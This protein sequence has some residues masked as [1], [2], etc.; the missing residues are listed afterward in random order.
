MKRLQRQA[1]LLAL[2]VSVLLH[3]ALLGSGW[4]PSFAPPP[5]SK[6]DPI[7]IRLQ[8][9]QLDPAPAPPAPA[10]KKEEKGTMSVAALPGHGQRPL[11]K[12]PGS[13]QASSSPAA[14]ASDVASRLPQ[15]EASAPQEDSRN[16]ILSPEHALPRFP[17]VA[18]LHYQVFYGALMAGVAIIDWQRSGNHYVLESRIR[19]IF[20]PTLRYRSSGVISRHGL[21]PIDYQAFRN[22]DAR[23][24]AHFDWDGLIL[25]Y[26]EDNRQ[27]VALQKG[28]QDIFSL[29]YQL[30]L[31]GSDGESV[32]ITTG[33]KVYQYPLTAVGQADFDTGFGKIHALV[34][35]ASGSDDTTEF[36]LAPDFANQPVRI[37]RS[38]T[39]MK[40]DM[41]V[42]DI[43]ID[44]NSEW[45][46]PKPTPRKHDK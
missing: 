6:L 16:A 41:R 46:L 44:D 38:D 17:K 39:R 13:D 33:K 18:Q 25:D 37:I 2:L 19:P 12:R 23:E 10:A 40:L 3:L 15:Q 30:A 45:H 42:T 5:D 36:W 35:R 24:H 27:Q 4:L 9:M 21:K 8:A 32:Q 26:G 29:I 20:G 1:L 11:K 43:V 34:F 28:A 7:S 31:K 14:V 22:D